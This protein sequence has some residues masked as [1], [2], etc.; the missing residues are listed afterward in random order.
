MPEILRTRDVVV[1]FKGDTYCCAVDNALATAGWRGGQGCQWV[2]PTRD[3]FLVGATDGLYAGFLLWGSDEASDQFTSMTRSQPTYRYAVV[4]AGGWL[5][6]TN[7]YERYTWL[8]RTGGG[9][10]VPLTYQ[11]SDRL[12]FS[13]RGYLT[14]EDEW[15]LSG[16]PRAP[17]TYYIA[18]VAQAPSSITDGY[19]T[20]QTSI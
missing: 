5:I 4:G 17:N 8:S 14:R 1:L 16:D 20:V 12:V 9:P 19:L 11:E 6:S 10:L 13:L 15:A 3:E 7:T 2:T 18:F